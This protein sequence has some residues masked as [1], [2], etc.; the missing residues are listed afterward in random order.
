[1]TNEHN[2]ADV[3]RQAEAEKNLLLDANERLTLRALRSQ[4]QAEESERRYLGQHEANTLLLEKQRQ[5]RSLA[6]E[7]ILSEQR[8]RKHLATE[9]HDYM[10]Q[11][12]VLGGLKISHIQ[13]RLRA[14]DPFLINSLGE[15]EDIFSRSLAYT[16]TL[17]AELSPPVLHELGLPAALQWL[18]QDMVKHGLNVE[19]RL[20]PGSLSLRDD[21]HVLLYQSIRELLINIVKH[22]KTSRASLSLSIE[23][24]NQLHIVIADQ[25]SGF[26]VESLA[27]RPA[28]VHFGLFSIRERMEAMGGSFQLDSAPGRGTT[29][30][31]TLP[32]STDEEPAQAQTAM[33]SRDRLHV[34][35]VPKV[36][37]VHR[38]L[39][40]DDHVIIRQGLRTI[41]EG[42]DD[43]SVIAEAGNGVEAVSLAAEMRPDTI[44]MDINMPKMDGIE[45]TKQI[46]AVQPDAI[47]IGLSVN[48]SPQI[49]EAMTLAGA[50]AFLSK[51]A[52]ADKLY[53]TIV[54]LR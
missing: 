47:V 53:D 7:L 40:V 41:L 32:L 36:S 31:L 26:D 4:E 35:P 8:Q 45:A 54:K 12:M 44:V 52:A 18:A 11:L 29:I 33:N 46:K 1:M 28:G 3:P 43:M 9:L 37:G 48:T 51:E 19:L 22:A 17:M 24:M 25:G 34:E 38:V 13:S 39:L 14:P 27:A 2:P 23:G 16:R 30:T 15:I 10:A 49:V 50:S 5:L 6:S 42:Y 21:Q 20:S